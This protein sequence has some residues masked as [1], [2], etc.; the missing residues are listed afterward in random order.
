M[1]RMS[2]VNRAS[3]QNGYAW[4]NATLGW[5]THQ[6]NLIH[7]TRRGFPPM[8]WMLRPAAI[9]RAGQHPGAL[10]TAP[11][12]RI[13]R[14]GRRFGPLDREKQGRACVE[15]L[16]RKLAHLPQTDHPLGC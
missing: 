7:G 4:M 16:R 5:A 12:R 1:M 15:Q 6:R 13:A 3:D 14:D 9:S 11:C 8:G 10:D 2:S